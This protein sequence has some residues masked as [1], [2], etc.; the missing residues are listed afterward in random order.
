LKDLLA[1][2]G[3]D[4]IIGPPEVAYGWRGN[5]PFVTD[6]SHGFSQPLEAGNRTV[7]I[8]VPKIGG[9]NEPRGLVRG[10]VIAVQLEIT[11]ATD[12]RPDW[13]FSVPNVRALAPFLTD[14]DGVLLHFDRPTADG[15][16][17]A[18]SSAAQTVSISAVPCVGIFDKLIEAS[19]WSGQQTP[20]GVFTSR[21]IE[22]L[23]GPGST[24]AN[25]PG[26]RAGLL[27]AAR[28]QQ[29]RVSGAIIQ[30]IRQ[31][32]GAWPGL[33]S[34]A[35]ARSDYHGGIFR[36]LL[37]RGILRP[38]LPVA[39]PHCTTSTLVRPEDL[40]TQMKC[41]MCLQDFPLGLALGMRTNGR[42][43]WH[44]QLAGHVGEHRLSEA[45]PVMAVLQVLTTYGY[46]SSST[47]PYLL[48]WKVQ[49]PGLDCEV[50][51]AAILDDRGRPV[52][53]VGEAKHHLK[54]ID[55]NDLHN[56][57]LL[58]RHF[59]EQ[60]IE[61]F[62]L[63]AVLRDLRQEEVDVLREFANQ[64]PR[65][66]PSQSSIEP[67]FPI[68]L[69]GRDLSVPPF[70]EHSNQWAPGDGVVG[71]ARESCRRNL[72]MTAGDYSSDGDRR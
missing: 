54:S 48:G 52:V 43:D 28:S 67:V 47:V 57:G 36:F 37:A 46:M 70:E 71:L 69:T 10:H 35:H 23:G 15:R 1:T 61:C 72:G 33:L 27:E 11:G 31:Y 19:G 62:I 56:L 66:L 49:G 5:H 40:V 34:S 58:Q 4:S 25:Q 65:T 45:L 38:S 41:E 44:Y 12:V 51:V 63:T 29:G 30:R 20:G 18:A 21:L 64:P 26:A 32:Q 53:V 17:L 50:D 13:T 68:V 14:Y 59:R 60:N 42:N 8:P 9:I 7:D 55:E 2:A 6:F 24:I 3:V 16:V 22:R 39:C